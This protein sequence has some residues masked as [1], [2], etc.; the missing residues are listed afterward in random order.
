MTVE[1]TVPIAANDTGG[2]RPFNVTVVNEGGNHNKYILREGADPEE[3][4][5]RGLEFLKNGMMESARRE[6]SAAVMEG[7]R[8]AETRFFLALAIMS[9]R[10]FDEVSGEEV[11]HLQMTEAWEHTPNADDWKAGFQAIC[12]LVEQDGDEAPEKDRPLPEEMSQVSDQV[13]KMINEHLAQHLKGAGAEQRWVSEQ[14]RAEGGQLAR[15]RRHRAWMFF[16]ADPIAPWIPDVSPIPTRPATWTQLL[17]GSALLIYAWIK[18]GSLLLRQHDVPGILAYLL[19]LVAVYV[20]AHHGVEWLYRVRRLRKKVRKYEATHH[21]PPPSPPVGGFAEDVD[22]R[23]EYYFNKHTPQRVP[24]SEWRRQTAAIQKAIREEITTQYR[25]ISTKGPAINWLIRYRVQEVSRRWSNGTLRDYHTSLQVPVVTKAATVAGSAVLLVGAGR[26]VAVAG[27]SGPFAATGLTILALIGG[28]FAAQGWSRLLVDRH[29]FA[30]ESAE[31]QRLKKECAAEFQ[32]WK[33]RL[34]D[35]PKDWEMADW[36]KC[37]RVLL[38]QAAMQQYNLKSNHV[39]TYASIEG[40]GSGLKQ[41]RVRGG[42][43]RYSTYRMVVFII[44]SGGVRQIQAS[45]NFEKAE[46]GTQDRF[47]YRFDA[48][49]SVGVL[50]QPSGRRVFDLRLMGGKSTEIDLLTSGSEGLADAEAED[51]ET[52]RVTLDSS[53]LD[54]TLHVLEGV[55]AE[56]KDWMSLERS[57][58]ADRRNESLSIVRGLRENA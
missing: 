6:I 51:A 36:L 14:T 42:P 43:W 22:R 2:D 20:V 33:N 27:R 10:T 32:R 12:R 1:L 53:G 18:I 45:L 29:L 13:R 46:F 38:R 17:G 5:Q 25:D 44:T 35:R 26:A 11:R 4:F 34:K 30:A 28:W 52:N 16:E 37:D 9:G 8:T 49:S 48:I 3:K 50:E 15:A 56:G 40:R 7:H 47:N 19:T 57:R 41:A 31:R 58:G 39:V 24:R 55:A 23:F 21:Q 54:R